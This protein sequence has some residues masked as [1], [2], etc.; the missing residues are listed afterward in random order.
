MN[1]YLYRERERDECQLSLR[2]GK[3]PTDPYTTLCH[4]NIMVYERAAFTWDVGGT[5]GMLHRYV[6]VISS[7]KLV[8]W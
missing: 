1:I 2:S 8:N 7:S 3:D 6:Q 4:F 5:C